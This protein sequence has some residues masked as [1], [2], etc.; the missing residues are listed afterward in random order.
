MA[1]REEKDK[2]DAEGQTSV[3]QRLPRISACQTPDAGWPLRPGQKRSRQWGDN[4]VQ[5]ERALWRPR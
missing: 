5:R 1:I 4:Q 3:R 2:Q